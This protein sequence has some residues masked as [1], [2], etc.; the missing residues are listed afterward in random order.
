MCLGSHGNWFCTRLSYLWLAVRFHWI[1]KGWRVAD[2]AV[3]SL[4][5]NI[6][7]FGLPLP[8]NVYSLCGWGNNAVTSVKRKAFWQLPL[9]IQ[10]EAPVW[11]SVWHCV[12][13]PTCTIRY[14][15]LCGGT[16][17]GSDDVT[18][19][20]AFQCG[21]IKWNH[22]TSVTYFGGHV[23]KPSTVCYFPVLSGEFS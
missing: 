3:A 7:T 13:G 14:T 18:D 20:D 4:C 21:R 6:S 2:P 17:W 23:T 8:M 19:T 9:R 5:G 16:L 22:G 15:H 10:R 12:Q 1:S 11:E